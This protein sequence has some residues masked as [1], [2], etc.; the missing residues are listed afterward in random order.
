MKICNS[1]PEND[2]S[3]PEIFGD[4]FCGMIIHRKDGDFG[5]KHLVY[6]KDRMDFKGKK[7]TCAQSAFCNSC[8]CVESC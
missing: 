4:V 8:S 2:N 5:E 6:D 3:S 7:G 1:S